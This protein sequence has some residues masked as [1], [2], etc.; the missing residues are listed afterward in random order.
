MEQHAI[1]ARVVVLSA[2]CDVDLVRDVIE[3]YGTGFILKATSRAI[4]INAVLLTLAGG[5]YIPEIALRQMG[6][7]SS[8]PP[9][10]TDGAAHGIEL[11]RREAQVAALL[12]HGHTYKRI[13]RELEKQDGHPISDHTVRVHVGRIAWKLGVTENVK[14][15]VMAEIA[16]R[17]LTFP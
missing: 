8:A 7:S 2:A 12:V 13:A 10:A 9:T 6:G 17:R 11:T 16:R 15:G 4:F 3:H 1:D 14:A 5:V